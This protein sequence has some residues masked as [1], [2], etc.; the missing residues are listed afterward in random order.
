MVSCG[1]PEAHSH[2]YGTVSVIETVALGDPV[3]L[4]TSTGNVT[5]TKSINSVCW[6]ELLMIG[7]VSKCCL[8]LRLGV[9]LVSS[10]GKGLGT[11]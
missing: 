8:Q 4:K 1:V 11:I 7:L 3:T 5:E 2:H 10:Q 6:S 9:F